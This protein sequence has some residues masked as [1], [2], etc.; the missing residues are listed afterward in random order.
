VQAQAHA[1]HEDVRGTVAEAHAVLEQRAP[2]LP[3]CEVAAASRVEP[4][5]G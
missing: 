1:A 5:E 2:Q 3:H 4:L